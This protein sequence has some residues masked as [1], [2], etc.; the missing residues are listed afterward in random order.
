MA[1]T[2][3]EVEEIFQ[4]KTRFPDNPSL[5]VHHSLH[6][7][8]DMGV[9][10]VLPDCL[11]ALNDLLQIGVTQKSPFLIDDVDA[12]PF[13]RIISMSDVIRL[14]DRILVMC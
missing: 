1:K 6:L 14:L 4:S 12:N 8:T 11:V 5:H 13:L 2:R 7:S 10:L 3:F 9:F